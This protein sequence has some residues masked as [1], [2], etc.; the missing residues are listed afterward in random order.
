MSDALQSRFDYP[1]PNAKHRT[2]MYRVLELMKDG[3]RR[4]KKEIRAALGLDPDIEITARI[5]DLRKPEHGSWVFNDARSDGPD[6]DGVFRYVLK[7][8]KVRE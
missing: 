6:P 3:Q 1:I 2:I 5:R 4:S 8:S 7:G